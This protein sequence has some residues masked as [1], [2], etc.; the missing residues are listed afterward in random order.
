LA[1]RAIERVLRSSPW[2]PFNATATI[3]DVGT[4]SG[5]LL[6]AAVCLGARSGMGIDIDPCARFEAQENVRLNGIEDQV[7]ISDAGFKELFQPVSLISANL[8]VPTLKQFSP[9]LARLCTTGGALVVSGVHGEELPDL[10]AVFQA[11]RFE[12]RWQ[13]WE[14]DWVAVVLQNK[15]QV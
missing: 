3:L 1:L 2:F 10:L 7:I 12:C 9:H 15:K 4:G 5:V 6:I 13:I 8:R 11:Q 14:Q